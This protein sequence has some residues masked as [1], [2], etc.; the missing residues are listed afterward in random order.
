MLAAI[1]KLL[2]FDSSGGTQLR[3]FGVNPPRQ[4]HEPIEI[5][6]APHFADFERSGGQG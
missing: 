4:L 5:G 1:E 3:I 2:D 6:P